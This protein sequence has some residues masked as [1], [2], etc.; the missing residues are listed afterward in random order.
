VPPSPPTAAPS[1]DEARRAVDLF[2]QGLDA[3]VVPV[4]QALARK[5]PQHGLGWMLLAASLARQQN[6][7]EALQPAERAVQ[8]MPDRAELHSNLGIAYYRLERL[9]E[10]E[11]SYR[12]ALALQP[13]HAQALFNLGRLQT[14]QERYA[15]SAATFGL[16]VQA[17]PGDGEAHAELGIAQAG[18]ERWVAAGQSHRRALALGHRDTVV[19]DHLA[20]ALLEQA[21]PHEA[22][23][24]LREAIALQPDAPRLLGNF[25]FTRN[26]V[27]GEEQP[28][29]PPQAIRFGE[30]LRAAAG[31]PST[32]WNCEPQP[33]V[34]RVGFVSAD[35]RRHPVASF[36]HGFIGHVGAHKL[37]LYAYATR[38]GEDAVTAR[39]KP[40][41]AG[42]RDVAGLSAR[43]AADRIAQ[44]G[45]HVLLDLSGHTA[46]NRL[47]VFALSPAPVQ[48]TWLGVPATTGLPAIH[49]VLTDPHASRPGDQ[50]WFS[51]RLWPLPESWFCYAPLE[52]AP[53]VAPL[54]A[55]ANGHLTFGSFN[56]M[57][58]LNDA[59]VRTWGRLLHA[60]AGSRL[61]LRNWQ[62]QDPALAQ[63]LR[64]RFAAEGIAPERLQFEGPIVSL[65]SH[66]AQY[67]RIDIALDT[68]PYVGGTTTT[69]ALY[70]GVPALTLRGSGR[71]LRLGE[72]LL[73]IAGLPDWIAGDENDYVDKAAAFASDLP[74]L[75][76]LRAGLRGRVS[77]TALLDGKRFAR[78]FADAMWAMWSAAPR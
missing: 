57:T 55:L 77:A 50:A 14:R 62:L 20:R 40:H 22:L 76:E 67:A 51:E 48:V 49:Y 61:L 13:T 74:R 9:A 69:E 42:W 11:R 17:H 59:V 73:Q 12:S 44:D 70:M 43:D 32:A 53:D 39:L 65:A 60:V 1:A 71:M 72:S 46:G 64:D 3:Q 36:L 26:H 6:Y 5:Y 35:L 52:P 15:E 38:S 78:Q 21:R 37:A 18:L 63:Q 28:G 30:V 10:A 31:Q 41:F 19:L 34:L 66:L 2:R 27:P 54:P 23:P 29:L 68:F 7:A 56:S 75:A 16:L 4:A 25:L 33:D 8:L 24:T 58:K 45:I 47:D